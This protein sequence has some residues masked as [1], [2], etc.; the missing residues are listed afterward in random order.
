MV[1]VSTTSLGNGDGG[2]GRC[3]IRVGLRASRR[4][5]HG[6]IWAIWEPGRLSRRCRAGTGG[7]VS[8]PLVFSEASRFWIVGNGDAEAVIGVGLLVA[9]R[10]HG[11]SGRAVHRRLRLK[12]RLSMLRTATSEVETKRRRGGNGADGPRA[13]RLAACFTAAEATKVKE[14][15]TGGHARPR[16]RLNSHQ[17]SERHQ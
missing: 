10:R 13:F 3:V 14:C 6:Q 1:V 8:R 16:T 9:G 15:H 11:A 17:I 4:G 5:P 7:L 2:L 12:P